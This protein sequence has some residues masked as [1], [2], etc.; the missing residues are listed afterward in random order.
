MRS[1]NLQRA[2]LGSGR[3]LAANTTRPLTGLRYASTEHGHEHHDHH[4][5]DAAEYPREGFATSTIVKIVTLAGAVV[6]FYKYAPSASEDNII[7]RYI[8]SKATPSEVWE[9]V[10]LKH[11]VLEQQ[12]AD[13]S[14]VIWAA[15]KPPV[16]RFRYPLQIDQALPHRQPVGSTVDLNNLVVKQ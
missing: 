10:N 15:Q 11:T 13:N 9:Q 2:V 14:Q 16:H 1:G 12:Q 6:A 5:E 8:S 4:V 7:S 3:Q